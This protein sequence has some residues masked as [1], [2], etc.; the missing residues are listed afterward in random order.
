MRACCLGRSRLCGGPAILQVNELGYR[1]SRAAADAT[2]HHVPHRV[3]E[4]AGHRGRGDGAGG[5]GRLTLTTRS[6]SGCRNCPRCG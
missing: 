5:G 3:D 4:Q 1:D 2:G 6:R